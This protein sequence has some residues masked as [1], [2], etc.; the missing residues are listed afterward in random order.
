MKSSTVT[1]LK[2][3]KKPATEGKQGMEKE[4]SEIKREVVESRNLVIKTDNLLKNLHAELKTVAKQGEDAAR[5]AWI[6]SAAA[7]VIFAGLCIAGAV[8]VSSASTRSAESERERL[9]KQV[10]DLTT[11][12][13][14]QKTELASNEASRKSAADV[15]RMMTSLPGDERLK[16]ID[17]LMKLDTAR[18]SPLE[19]AALNDRA[20][21]LRKEIGSV[22]FER[23]KAAFRRNEMK[24]TVTE[25]TRFMAMNPSQ[26]DTLEA[27]FFLGVAHNQLRDYEK[28]VPYF[29]RFVDGNRR[30]KNRDYA[31]MLLA[32][33]LERTG[34]AEKAYEIA[35]D[36]IAAYPGSEFVP[37]LRTRMNSA[38]REMRAASGTPEPAAAPQAAPATP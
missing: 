14:L 27:S 6:A 10:T 5:K 36:A 33:S 28:A 30:S 34:Q 38:R 4:L 23:G 22:A 16:G 24:D 25:L 17:A 7:Y 35:R 37:Q 31:M 12:L 19:R 8:L 11:Q 9:S 3:D 1:S 26:E 13:Q 29:T 21:S 15:Y 18:L 20:E 32:H 2:D